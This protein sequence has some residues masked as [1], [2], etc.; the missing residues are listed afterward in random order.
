MPGLTKVI[1]SNL[2]TRVCQTCG[3]SWH[4]R[5]DRAVNAMLKMH[6]KRVH[7]KSIQP[8]KAVL[9]EDVIGACPG[10]RNVDHELQRIHNDMMVDG[11]A[12]A[13]YGVHV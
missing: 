6:F 9:V 11:L 12:V 4:G 13:A 8:A 5:S 1:V 7:G 3:R 2:H 10:N